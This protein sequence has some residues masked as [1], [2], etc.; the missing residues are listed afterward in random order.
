MNSDSISPLPPIPAGQALSSPLGVV[1]TRDESHQRDQKRKGKRH[2]PGDRDDKASARPADG[3]AAE[4][5]EKPAV[6][7]DDESDQHIIDY[8]T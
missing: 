7:C 4:S 3:S 2:H 6:K 5:I 1:L 8:Y